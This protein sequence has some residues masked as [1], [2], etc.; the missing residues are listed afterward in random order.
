MKRL[1][2]CLVALPLSAWAGQDD[3]I[4]PSA[5]PPLSDGVTAAVNQTQAT[6][7]KQPGVARVGFYQFTIDA[8]GKLTKIG[9]ARSSG[10]ATD[11]DEAIAAIEATPFDAAPAGKQTYHLIPIRFTAQETI[12][13]PPAGSK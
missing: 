8:K 4:A 13:I 10:D 12:Y 3:F 9:I 5:F 11:D 6:M 2:I 7:L 1:L